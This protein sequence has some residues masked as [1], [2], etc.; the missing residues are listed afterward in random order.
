MA[1]DGNFTVPRVRAR[2]VA[3]FEWVANGHVRILGSRWNLVG[4]GTS[5]CAGW[6]GWGEPSSEVV[7]WLD[8]WCADAKT[9]RYHSSTDLRET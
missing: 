1:G 2:G 6:G 3:V 9:A 4:Q 8:K 5:A 7:R